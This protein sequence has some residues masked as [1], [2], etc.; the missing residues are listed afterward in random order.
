MI[1]VF[2]RNVKNEIHLSPCRNSIIDNLMQ[3]MIY[4]ANVTAIE[5]LTLNKRLTSRVWKRRNV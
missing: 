1:F 5:H 2:C 4:K 3:P